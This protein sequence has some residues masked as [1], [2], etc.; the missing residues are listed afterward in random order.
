[1]PSYT[2]IITVN[3]YY[4]DLDESVFVVACNSNLRDSQGT[5][6]LPEI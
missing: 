5:T 1:M 3:L 2:F 4:F 6:E